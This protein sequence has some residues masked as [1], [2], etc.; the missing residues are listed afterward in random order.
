MMEDLS[1]RLMD[2]TRKWTRIWNTAATISAVVA[3]RYFFLFQE[4]GLP[5]F[6]FLPSPFQSH[7]AYIFFVVG[8]LSTVFMMLAGRSARMMLH[9]QLREKALETTHL[10]ISEK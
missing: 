2:D 5:A 10:S 1:S 6:G 7:S 8:G 3:L 9:E 4:F